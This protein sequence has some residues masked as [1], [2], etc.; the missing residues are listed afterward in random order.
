MNL[1]LAVLIG[2]LFA[3]GIF[4]ML[5]RNIFKLIMGV[6][7]FSYATIYFLFIVSGVTQNNPPLLKE[8][9]AGNLAEMADPLPQ[10]LTLTAIVIGVGIQLF[11][12]VL[13]KKVY[14]TMGSE[15]LDELNFT[16]ESD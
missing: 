8:D 15:D 12:I 1:I 14:S 5:H 13:L 7:V 6:I 3:S 10:A 2:V 4:L 9:D 16:D 11:L